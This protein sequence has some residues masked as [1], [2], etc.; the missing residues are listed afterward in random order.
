[1]HSSA[2][3]VALAPRRP[4]RITHELRY[5]TDALLVVAGLP[6]AGKST[7]I[8][9]LFPPDGSDP[10]TLDPE[11]IR[12]RWQR[13]LRTRRG[14]RL[15]RPLVHLEHYLRFALAMRRP[16]PLVLH[17]TATR[18]WAR[19]ALARLAAIHG[20]P[21]HLLFLDVDPAEAVR[22]EH[23]RGRRVRRATMARH[24]AA[25][26]RLRAR[27]RRPGGGATGYATT[28]VLDRRAAAGLTAIVFG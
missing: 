26:A 14:Y 25:W 22:G 7:L 8:R 11:T 2:M 21:A 27:L 13:L 19:R 1:M 23:A 15:Y 20:R 16:G 10:R 6:G 3:T 4:R 12:A 9:R 17:D 18:G 5:P 28:T 24:A